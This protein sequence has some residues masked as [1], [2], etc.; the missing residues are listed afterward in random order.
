[1]SDTVND[2]YIL[3][4]NRWTLYQQYE[5]KSLTRAI[6]DAE[7]VLASGKVDA[8]GVIREGPQRPG[9]PVVESLAYCDTKKDNVPD[10]NEH[11]ITPLSQQDHNAQ[12]GNY[13]EDQED[14]NEDGG[15]KRAAQ[16]HA[17]PDVPLGSAAA[18]PLKLFTVAFISLGVGWGVWAAISNL[19][20]ASTL[21]DLLGP[22]N[23]AAKT[24]GLG[25]LIALFILIPATISRRDIAAAFQSRPA[26][27]AHPPAQSRAPRRS[28][29]SRKENEELQQAGKKA[30]DGVSKKKKAKGE[31]PENSD[32]PGAREEDAETT[33]GEEDADDGADSGITS[34]LNETRAQLVKFFERCM[35]YVMAA[36]PDLKG[37]RLDAVTSFGCQLFFAGA[38]EVLIKEQRMDPG[39]LGKVLGPCAVALGQ[40]KDQVA[41]FAEKYESYLLEPGYLDMFRA[42]REAMVT[43]LADEIKAVEK[44]AAAEAEAASGAP[45]KLRSPADDDFDDDWESEEDIGIFLAHA[46]DAWRSPKDRKGSLTAVLFTDIVGSTSSTQEHGDEASQV[47]VNIHNSIVRGALQAHG[48]W[49][50]KHTGDGIMAGFSNP[51][52]AVDAGVEMQR[53]VAHYNTTKPDIELRLRVGISVGEPIAED[54]DLFG[55]TV[56]MAARLCDGAGTDGVMITNMLRE[57]C[58]GRA[59]EFQ[60]VEPKSF[61]GIADP[62]PVSLVE[63]RQKQKKRLINPD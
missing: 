27:G 62:V 53:G 60:D 46:L 28:A 13:F 17:E 41:K 24:M 6:A 34:K 5:G 48:G 15:R 45:K 4:R 40:S 19:G 59:L 2:L 33:S 26:G 31:R 1:L 3:S 52:A 63:W 44:A 49:E 56:Q 36:D 18:L 51:P 35:A 10:L 14:D 47:M 38:A 8:V 20:A 32:E 25:F 29:T 21:M 22:R 39:Q 30:K 37:G 43:A 61:K 42:G 23:T 54:D 16:A 11:K 12:Q 57:M 58:Q 7:K 9:G 50:V 55:A